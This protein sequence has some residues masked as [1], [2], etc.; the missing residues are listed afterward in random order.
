MLY[1]EFRGIVI[2][3]VSQ[4]NA[5]ITLWVLLNNYGM[6]RIIL[7]FRVGIV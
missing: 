6:K 4:K 3:I 1:P 2:N 7:M 5:W